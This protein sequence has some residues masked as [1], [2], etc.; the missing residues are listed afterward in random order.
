[1][2]RRSIMYPAYI[3]QHVSMEVSRASQ[4]HHTPHAKRPQMEPV[5]RFTVANASATSVTPAA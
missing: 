5:T 4:V 1:M 2:A 3:S